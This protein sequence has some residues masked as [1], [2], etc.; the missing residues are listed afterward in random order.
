MKAQQSLEN[1]ILVLTRRL[2][3][4]THM[5][6]SD[7]LGQASDHN[8]I[9]RGGMPPVLLPWRPETYSY[10]V[11]ILLHCIRVPNQSEPVSVTSR[12][13]IP[14]PPVI[15][16]SSLPPVQALPPLPAPLPAS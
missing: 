2:V 8:C 14:I 1:F 5:L 16:I 11:D 10:D 6:L 7:I 3:Y 4:D 12:T 15:L 13:S 9:V